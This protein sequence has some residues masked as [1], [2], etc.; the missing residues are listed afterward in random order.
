MQVKFAKQ[1]EKQGKLKVFLKFYLCKIVNCVC[2][3]AWVPLTFDFLLQMIYLMLEED[4]TPFKSADQDHWMWMYVGDKLF[5][6]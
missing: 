1:R 5:Y 4:C 3:L 2:I 6:P